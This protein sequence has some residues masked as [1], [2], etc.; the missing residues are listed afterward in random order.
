MK[1]AS[2]LDMNSAGV[3]YLVSHDVAARGIR[4]SAS[5]SFPGLRS[6]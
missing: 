5:R 2:V 3:R 4:S 6:G 1:L